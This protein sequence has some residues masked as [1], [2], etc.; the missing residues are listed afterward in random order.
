MLVVLPPSETKVSGGADGSSLD[1]KSL[2]TAS[3]TPL[4]ENL[5]RLLVE[6][7]GNPTLAMKDLKLGPQG[8]PEVQRNREVLG[9]PVMPALH[10]YTGVLYDALDVGTWTSED[11]DFGGRHLAVFSALFGLIRGSDRIPAYRLSSDS[12]LGQQKIT[13]HFAGYREAVWDEVTEFVLDL[14][15]EGY[16]SLAPFPAGLGVFISLVQPGTEGSTKALCHQK[17]Q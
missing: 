4:R 2:A 17:K 10:R 14:R 6:Q 1:L 3:L 16:S 8:A 9:S 15:S 11:W 12:T 7:A 13:K 5:L